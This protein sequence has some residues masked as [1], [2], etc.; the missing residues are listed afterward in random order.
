LQ[1][2]RT[3]KFT[4][5]DKI[6]DKRKI[7][8]I[9]FGA[10]EFETFQEASFLKEA[11]QSRIKE[12]PM[13]ST[14]RL[15]GLRGFTMLAILLLLATPGRAQYASGIEGTVVDQSGAVVPG[16][17]CTVT[18]QDTQVQ[19]TAISDA[20]GYIRILHL[21]PGKYRIQIGAPGFE[22]WEQKD[23]L[24]EGGALRAVYPKLKVGQNVATVEVRAETETLETSTS[25]K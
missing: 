2:A 22:K 7:V 19:Q 1:G 24:V 21:A 11:R 17:Q 15:V 10:S 13:V 12:T 23:V 9:L 5:P 14:L 6:V 18:N 3:F 16:A 4:T 25:S 8:G 20:Q